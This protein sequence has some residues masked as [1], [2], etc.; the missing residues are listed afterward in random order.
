[1][2]DT[3]EGG[4]RKNRELSRLNTAGLAILTE[5]KRR[6]HRLCI[7]KGLKDRVAAHDARLELM[8][9]A[10]GLAGRRKEAWR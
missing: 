6:A 3:L 9:A 2:D 4:V 1:M 5:G 10:G 7:S 8:T